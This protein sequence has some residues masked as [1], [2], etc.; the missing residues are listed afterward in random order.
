[1]VGV[2]NELTALPLAGHKPKTHHLL[3]GDSIPI[4]VNAVDQ[5]L[6]VAE[7][8][9]C[10]CAV[11]Q[12][13]LHAGPGFPIGACF[14]MAKVWPR[15]VGGDTGCGV[16][17]SVCKPKHSGDA[18]LRRVD[19][20]F[21]ESRVHDDATL[22]AA[23]YGGIRGLAE[24]DSLPDRLRAMAAAAPAN[25][26]PPSG[27]PPELSDLD[28]IGAGN[29]FA[30]LSQIGEV[31][32]KGEAKALGLSRKHV[33]VLVHS[34]SRGVGTRVAARWQCDPL[35]DPAE[36]MGQLAGCIRF[37]EANRFLLSWRLLVALGSTRPALSSFD[38]VHNTVLPHDYAGQ[39][40]FLHR[41]GCA[42]AGKDENTVVLGTRGTP[43]WV[44]KGLGNEE[45]LAS[46][47]HGAGRRLT[48][49]DARSRFRDKHKRSDLRRTALGGHVLCDRN[50]VLYEEHP[51]AYKDIGPVVDAI[52]AH[53]LARR[54]ASLHPLITVKR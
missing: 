35:D 20:A 49:S 44:M 25:T 32:D 40:S 36:Y 1:M 11:G 9:D 24:L 7:R 26:L 34:G 22:R 53:G 43:S 42:P 30:E 46:V 37:A 39:P 15:L 23:W 14:A 38:L 54:I 48:R 17:L 31:V 28:S 18:L 3:A 6:A 33:A 19:E 16:R 47:A 52:E 4:E 27:D 8:S 41:K 5:L 21:L 51:D 29:H 2:D 45:L 50:E 12:A 10:L 13:D